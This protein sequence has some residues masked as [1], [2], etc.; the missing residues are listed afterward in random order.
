MRY[1]ELNNEQERE[2]WTQG[3]WV[4]IRFMLIASLIFIIGWKFFDFCYQ[5]EQNQKKRAQIE[6]EARQ[7]EHNK[8]FT[9][10]DSDA[11]ETLEPFDIDTNRLTQ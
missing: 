8:L 7:N 6:A 10:L 3:F 1:S 2:I 9:T 5:S 11:I 4:G